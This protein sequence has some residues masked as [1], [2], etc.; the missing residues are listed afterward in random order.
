MVG[1]AD[2]YGNLITSSQLRVLKPNVTAS[3]TPVR[4]AGGGPF[5]LTSDEGLITYTPTPKPETDAMK[6][7]ELR[8]HVGVFL[9]ARYPCTTETRNLKPGMRT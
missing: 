4:L 3:E 9:W 2:Q 7:R 1:I 6:E 5:L 8:I